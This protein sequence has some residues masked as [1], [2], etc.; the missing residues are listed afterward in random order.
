[1]AGIGPVLLDDTA[2]VDR[3]QRDVSFDIST[4]GTTP[5]Q[6]PTSGALTPLP[7]AEIHGHETV[8][9]PSHCDQSLP[10]P[11]LYDPASPLSAVSSSTA[12]NSCILPSA[13]DSTYFQHRFCT[14]R[15][16]LASGYFAYYILSW[17]DGGRSL[18]TPQR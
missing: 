1:M 12:Q 3:Q 13:E 9:A 17:A 4:Q 14:L 16:R 11:R 18:S 8:V 6:L 10:N 7:G 5:V 15:W 2:I